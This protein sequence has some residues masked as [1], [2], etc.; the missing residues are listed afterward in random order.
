MIIANMS[1]NFFTNVDVK[2][3]NYIT[4]SSDHNFKD[5]LHSE[6]GVSFNFK[7]VSEY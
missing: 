1:N 6:R 2:L 7:Y 5:Y 4:V 3:A